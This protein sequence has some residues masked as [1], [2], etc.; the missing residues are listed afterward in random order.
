MIAPYQEAVS[1][2]SRNG[3]ATEL[4]PHS[5]EA[6]QAVLG[7]MLRDNTVIR[8]VVR[9]LESSQFYMDAH[10]RIFRTIVALWQAGKAVDLVTLADALHDLGMIADIGGYVYLAELW[11]A[12]PTAANAEHYARIVRDK[13]GRRSALYVA[14]Q[15]GRD[16][17][18][19]TGP[20]DELLDQ[21]RAEIDR[22]Q[23]TCAGNDAEL[24][25]LLS[26]VYPSDI[27]WLWLGRIPLGK[28]TVIDGDPG[29][30]KSVLSLDLAARV[31]TGQA[32][33][34][35]SP[36]KQG[37]VVLLSAEDGLDD[38]IRPRLDAAG[39]AVNRVLALDRVPADTGQGKRLPALPYDAPYLRAAVERMGAVLVIVD[40]LTAYLGERVNAHR[41]GDCRRALFPLAELAQESGA[42]VVVIRHLNKGGGTNPLY[43]GG[44]SIGIIG[45][46]RS[47][48]LVA[49]DP[50][51]SDRRIL[52]ATKCNLARLPPSLAYDLSTD[53]NGA[54]RIGWIG[55][56]PHSAER[57]LASAANDEE[58][59]AVAEAVE[60]LRAILATGPVPA[61]DVKKEAREAGVAEKTLLRAKA[62]VGVTSRKV[63]FTGKG[64]WQW[65]LNETP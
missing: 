28:L 2:T 29:L 42:A 26:T 39:A 14:Q 13:F 65:S 23:Q 51:N 35:G 34:D 1:F 62:V 4:P 6:E 20:L 12:A 7:S 50:D 36:G 16:A 49:R 8:A 41:D 61:E 9:I 57:L 60:V 22:I 15:F 30:G 5:R 53:D 40:P 44:G 63:G 37:G 33:P 38:T 21:T 18:T 17:A 54:L 25:T 58:R 24:G 32:M 19:P 43:R 55:E 45:A 10:Q 47:G 3:D 48:L 56:S 59:D 11:D 64:I 46:A 27:D 52:A 31:S